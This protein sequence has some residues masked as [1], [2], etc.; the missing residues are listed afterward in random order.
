MA[1]D[2]NLDALAAAVA[3]MRAQ[4]GLLREA[5]ENRRVGVLCGKCGH[6]YERC[7]F[8]GCDG[9]D[10]HM[11]ATGEG[12]VGTETP[13]TD[14][15]LIHA[16]DCALRSTPATALAEVRAR[17]TAPTALRTEPTATTRMTGRASRSFSADGRLVVTHSESVKA[18][19]RRVIE[20]AD[21]IICENDRGPYIDV[22]GSKFKVFTKAVLERRAL[23]A[24]TCP[25]CSG[26]AVVP[27]TGCSCPDCEGTFTK[28]PAKCAEGRV[29]SET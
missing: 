16:D 13:C 28:C 12:W 27:Y 22:T 20:A 23:E 21:A 19:E 9:H 7:L 18:Q 10:T 25:A 11:K 26:H 15:P 17:A 2:L 14:G 8:C 29:R 4:V 1:D 24:Q 3:A 5:C 6:R